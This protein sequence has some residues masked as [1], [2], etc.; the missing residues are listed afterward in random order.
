MTFTPERYFIENADIVMAANSSIVGNSTATISDDA[1]ESSDATTM[2][3]EGVS[4]LSVVILS[5]AA[6]SLLLYS[7]S[8]YVRKQ[9]AS[10]KFS[11]VETNPLQANDHDHSNGMNGVSGNQFSIEEND[12]KDESETFT[13]VAKN[14]RNSTSNV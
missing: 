7:L 10:P 13:L 6:A 5:L 11:S 12:T 1:G 4:V 9:Y 3:A 8:V 14:T 2:D